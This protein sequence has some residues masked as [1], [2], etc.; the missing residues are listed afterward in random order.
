[1]FISIDTVCFFKKA[2]NT[3]LQFRDPRVGNKTIKKSK[4]LI[5]FKNQGSGYI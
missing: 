1:M 2:G 3:K 5:T 4:K